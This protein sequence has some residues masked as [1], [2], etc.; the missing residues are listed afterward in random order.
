MASLVQ[1]VSPYTGAFVVTVANIAIRRILLVLVGYEKHH[2]RPQ[3]DRHLFWG[4]FL[5]Q[6]VNVFACVVVGAMA[7]PGLSRLVFPET[8]IAQYMFQG[9]FVFLFPRWYEEVGSKIV[10]LVLVNR[11]M[12]ARGIIYRNLKRKLKFLVNRGSTLL[13]VR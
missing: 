2:T 5:T 6:L 9:K 1:S 3:Q 12:Y 11:V 13:Q 8:T 7:T 10:A 4:I